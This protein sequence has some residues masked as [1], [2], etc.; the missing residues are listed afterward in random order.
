MASLPVYPPKHTD[1]GKSTS[2]NYWARICSA[3]DVT[4]GIIIITALFWSWLSE[5]RLPPR[6]IYTKLKYLQTCISLFT[7]WFEFTTTSVIKSRIVL[8]VSS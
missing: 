6:P 4:W 1:Y 2:Q 5:G 8:H 3:R 7:L